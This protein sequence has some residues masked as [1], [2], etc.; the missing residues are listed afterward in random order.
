MLKHHKGESVG[1]LSWDSELESLQKSDFLRAK[2]LNA[3]SELV[4]YLN[5]EQKI[6]WANKAA[7]ESV[8]QSVA[9]LGGKYCYA[10]WHSR[11]Q[12]C[13]D[14]PV[15]KALETGIPQKAELTS[16]DGRTWLVRGY[17]VREKDQSLLGAVEVT[18]E[19]TQRKLAEQAL[20]ESEE[21]Y[22]TLIQASPDAV[23]VTDIGGRITYVSP[24][25]LSLH[26]FKS[27]EELLGK[28]FFDLIAPP[29]RAQAILYL[30]KTLKEGVTRNLEYTLLKKN[31]DSFVG[32][33]DT[34]VV[35]DSHGNPQTFIAVTRD[36]T[37]RKVVQEKLESSVK[38]KEYLLQEIHHRVK[39]NLQVISSILD[40]SRI[41]TQD[42]IAVGL[43]T[44]ARSKI[45]T[46][47]FIHSQLYRSE[48]FDRI[49]MGAHTRDLIRYLSSVYSVTGQVTCHVDIGKVYLSLTQS[50]PCALILNEL[51]SNAFKHAFVAQ[52]QG[53]IEVSMAIAAGNAILLSVKDDGIGM[54]AD[55]DLARVE[56]MG[57]KLVKNLVERQLKGSIKLPPSGYTEFRIRFPIFKAEE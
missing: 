57:L 36:I 12:P 51:I 2:I 22:K 32:E 14:C 31:G 54:P 52:P 26:G 5:T 11:N 20:Q 47:A 41:R 39:N 29:S 8:N 37:A 7:A 56:S 19:I 23:T 25:I 43:I 27:K 21:R 55:F 1:S 24:Q 45:Q 16:P 9:E 49:E 3:I 30:R 17:P 13:V 6:I 42:P 28:K 4:V 48:R 35:R 18:L 46:M 44:N 53:T 50:I 34:A 33:I 10:V 38:E 15:V 40:M